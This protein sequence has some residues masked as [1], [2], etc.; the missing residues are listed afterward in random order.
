MAFITTLDAVALSVGANRIVPGRAI[1]NPVG[2]PNLQP[3]EER[4]FRR[5]LV[6]K[7]LRALT[8]A[9]EGPTIFN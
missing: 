4:R 3:D 8:T 2:D 9:V 6:E 7:A 1:T 5:Q